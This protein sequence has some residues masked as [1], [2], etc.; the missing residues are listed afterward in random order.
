[1]SKP[2]MIAFDASN[3]IE[4]MNTNLDVLASKF[5]G[6]IVDSD[7][8][9]VSYAKLVLGGNI[10]NADINASAGIVGTKLAA[11]TIAG[12]ASN[13]LAL[14]TV[15]LV[16]MV[17]GAVMKVSG[18]TVNTGAISAYSSASETDITGASVSYTPAESGSKILA[19]GQATAT[20]QNNA[21]IWQLGV[22]I[23]GVTQT[24]KPKGKTGSSA[25]DPNTLTAFYFYTFASGSAQT[26]KLVCNGDGSNQFNIAIGDSNLWIIEFKRS[27]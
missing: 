22:N 19:F 13:Q 11:N 25:G 6:A 18:P 17:I 5:D 1:M 9:S 7:I 20:R 10:V 8:S 24:Y 23:A 15:D 16:N 21:P 26:V 14:S 2:T 12:G 27:A 3:P 4:D